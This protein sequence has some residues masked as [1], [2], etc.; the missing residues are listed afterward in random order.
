MTNFMI[1]QH[2][3]II[4]VYLNIYYLRIKIILFILFVNFIKLNFYHLT[5]AITKVKLKMLIWVTK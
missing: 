2:S 5:C 4:Y 1:Q 3:C